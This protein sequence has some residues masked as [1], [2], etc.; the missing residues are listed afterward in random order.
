[1]TANLPGTPMLSGNWEGY[2]ASLGPGNPPPPLGVIPPDFEMCALW[3]WLNLPILTTS[4][5]TPR[6]AMHSMTNRSL[7]DIHFL[8]SLVAS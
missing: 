5:A 8:P 6:V 2:L 1:M 3:P 7:I 4:W